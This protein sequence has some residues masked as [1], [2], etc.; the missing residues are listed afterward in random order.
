MNETIT[1]IV[2]NLV[3]DPILR[4]TASGRA[5]ANIRIAS[6]PRYQAAGEWKD[7]ATLY[8][9]CNIWGQ[10]A[11]N[12]A[13]SLLRGQKVIA[14]GRLKQREYQTQNGDRRTFIELDVEDIGPSLRTAIAKVTKAAHTNAQAPATHQGSSPWGIHARSDAI[15]GPWASPPT[16]ANAT[17]QP[18]F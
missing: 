16:P 15:S 5:V 13:E 18:P 4:F 12:V 17:T 3:E 11:E 9:T 10:Q 1:T 8:L 2:G 14:R 6:T 7:G